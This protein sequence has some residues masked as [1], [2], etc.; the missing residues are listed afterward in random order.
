M[1]EAKKGAAMTK[2][3]AEVKLGDKVLVEAQV[4]RLKPKRDGYVDVK[5]YDHY[6]YAEDG[7]DL[8]DA[9]HFRLPDHH[10]YP[11][12]STDY[13]TLQQRCLELTECVNILLCEDDCLIPSDLR[14][15]AFAILGGEKGV[16]T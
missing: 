7:S 10:V 4:V 15:K 1:S 6:Y 13:A 9:E 14:S 8:E 3:T 12:P 16:G 11:L 2:T 5:I